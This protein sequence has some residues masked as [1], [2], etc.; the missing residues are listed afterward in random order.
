MTS[1]DSNRLALEVN[2]RGSSYFQATR[3]SEA[4]E[5]YRRATELVGKEN[6]HRFVYMLNLANACQMTWQ[7]DEAESI[8]NHLLSIDIPDSIKV[9]VGDEIEKLAA[10]RSRGVPEIRSNNERLLVIASMMVAQYSKI[11]RS[12]NFVWLDESEESLELINKIQNDHN[13][14]ESGKVK[15]FSG[16]TA[17]GHIIGNEHWIFVKSNHWEKATDS[18]LRGLLSHELAHEELKDTPVTYAINPRQSAVAFICN[19]RATDL[20]A[21]SKGFGR[22][23]LASRQYMESTRGSF[24]HQLALMSPQE[25][26]AIIESL[27][28]KIAEANFQSK[29]AASLGQKLGKNSLVVHEEF[30]KAVTLWQLVLDIDP[31]HSFALQE[32]HIANLWLEGSTG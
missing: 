26:S 1:Y 2:E 18:Q 4:K 7:Y 32:L 13:T 15:S 17:L 21:I 11:Q 14:P 10:R 24:E 20:I 23:L 27:A 25:I 5:D 28:Y 8:Y 3:Y 22:D 19:E 31:L 12:V 16:W 9:S 30:H 6:S 29:F